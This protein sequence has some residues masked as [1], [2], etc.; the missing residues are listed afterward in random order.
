M[1]LFLILNEG[2]IPIYNS[3]RKRMDKV[4]A[5]NV[6]RDRMNPEIGIPPIPSAN[7]LLGGRMSR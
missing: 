3:Q 2:K 6:E 5:A 7:S 1:P 4:A